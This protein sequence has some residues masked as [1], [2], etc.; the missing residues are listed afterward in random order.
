MKYLK[1][2]YCFFFFPL[3]DFLFVEGV[4]VFRFKTFQE[5][6][7]DLKYYS[8]KTL[9]K[10]KNRK[11]Y[12]NDSYDKNNLI[13]SALSSF[14]KHINEKGAI[15]AQDGSIHTTARSYKNYLKDNDLV[16]KDWKDGS[17]KPKSNLDKEIKQ[18]L[19]EKAREL[20]ININT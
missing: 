20:N 9:D 4:G 13:L 5:L 3:P 6:K 2:K 18:V 17:N 8:K 15:V 11:Y 1:K 10:I 16:I 7:Q 19:L 12:R 14:D